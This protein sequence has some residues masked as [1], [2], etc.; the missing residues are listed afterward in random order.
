MHQKCR[1]RVHSRTHRLADEDGRSIKAAVDGLRAAGLLE[2][3]SPAF[4]SGISQSQEQTDGR[5]ETIIDILF[6][7]PPITSQSDQPR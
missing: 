3:D 4:V 1:V 7:D 6:D 5:E 2:D